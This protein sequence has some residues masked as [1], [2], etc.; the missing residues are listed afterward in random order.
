MVFLLLIHLRNFH[1]IIDLWYFCSGLGQFQEELRNWIEI[2]TPILEFGIELE[3]NFRVKKELELELELN[4]FFK[5]EL[6]LEL[7]LIANGSIPLKIPFQFL[8]IPFHLYLFLY[9]ITYK[10]YF[11]W[12]IPFNYF[13]LFF[14]FLK[15]V[16]L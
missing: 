10:V 4:F 9:Q 8:S 14:S 6:E 16:I 1:Q 3:L 15:S 13:S 12:S 2:P 7:E 5:K 11:N